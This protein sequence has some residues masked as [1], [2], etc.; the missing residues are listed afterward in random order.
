MQHSGKPKDPPPVPLN[1]SKHLPHPPWQILWRVG[2]KSR[3]CIIHECWWISIS[4]TT[5]TYC[6]EHLCPNSI[7]HRETRQ[8]MATVETS[9]V[10]HC[11][12]AR[13]VNNRAHALIQF[14]FIHFF[15]FFFNTEQSLCCTRSITIWNWSLQ[16][17]IYR[18]LFIYWIGTVCPV[19]FPSSLLFM[20][21]LPPTLSCSFPWLTLSLQCYSTREVMMRNGVI[22]PVVKPQAAQQMCFRDPA[23]VSEWIRS[24]LW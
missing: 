5:L 14:L 20:L 12:P 16:G 24:L 15:F 22:M 3:P 7:L 9:H 21:R 17:N 10:H 11:A 23:F 2:L 1:L 6:W 19:W 4:D 18:N 8:H 13:T